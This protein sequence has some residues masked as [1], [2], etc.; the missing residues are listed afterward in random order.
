MLSS[1]SRGTDLPT[2]FTMLYTM[3]LLYC[4]VYCASKIPI[5]LSKLSK[6]KHCL[7]FAFVAQN[8]SKGEG[9]GLLAQ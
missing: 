6:V 4:C 1:E 5:L 8:R 9:E 7:H 3:C 2:V